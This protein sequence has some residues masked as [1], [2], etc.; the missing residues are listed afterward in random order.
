MQMILGRLLLLLAIAASIA[1][2]QE[3]APGNTENAAQAAEIDAL[4]PGSSSQGVEIL[5]VLASLHAV[6]YE[7]IGLAD[8]GKP[9]NYFGRQIGRWSRQ[10]RPRC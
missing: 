10:Y 1:V 4:E 5:R 7:A 8:Y 2:A 9:G 6:D 3:T